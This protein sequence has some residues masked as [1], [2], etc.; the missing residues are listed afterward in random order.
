MVA[1][2]QVRLGGSLTFAGHRDEATGLIEVALTLAQHH[3]LGEQLAQGLDFKALLL[4]RDGRAEEAG[5]LFE[6]CVSVS[7]REGL[8]RTELTAEVNLA[9]LCMTHDLPGADEH[10]EAALALARRWGLRSHE[11]VAVGN[12]MYALM[13]A[14]RLG[15]AIQLGTEL[16]QA[17][18]DGRPGAE[19]VHY[20]LACLEAFRGNAP[21]AR[22]HVARCH[23][24][25]D[26]DDVQNKA[27]HAAVQ[28]AVFL[29]G[30]DGRQAVESRA[31]RD[32]RG[33]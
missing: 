21:G 30:G 4:S 12:L 6:L 15:E 24:W 19:Q 28:A 16:L 25:A 22:E 9:D 10:A 2:L 3:E 18:G 5:A 29:A 33:S 13:M 32:R 23:A 7:R 20:S 17:G 14:G 11:A 31:P 1:E 26:S 27:V 8:P